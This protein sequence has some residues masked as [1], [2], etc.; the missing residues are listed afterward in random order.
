MT[1]HDDVTS[2]TA[3]LKQQD[4]HR[5]VADLQQ[6]VGDLQHASHA[7]ETLGPAPARAAAAQ[8]TAVTRDAGLGSLH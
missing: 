7:P 8:V 5:A 1:Q 3:G 6:A 2:G 4:L